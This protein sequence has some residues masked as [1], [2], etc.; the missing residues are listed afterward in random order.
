MG[1][2][3]SLSG[4]GT[5]LPD[6]NHAWLWLPLLLAWT[7]R[8]VDAGDVTRCHRSCLLH[9]VRGWRCQ[10]HTQQLEVDQGQHCHIPRCHRPSS[11]VDEQN[12]VAGRRIRRSATTL[13]AFYERNSWLPAWF[14]SDHASSGRRPRCCWRLRRGDDFETACHDTML[15]AAS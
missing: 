3:S 15:C 5:H 11:S 13:H 1:W 2:Q 4:G 10:Q 9:S 6:G 12:A 7:V 8:S 14:N